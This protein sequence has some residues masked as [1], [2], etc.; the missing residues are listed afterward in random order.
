M[1]QMD[2][3]LDDVVLKALAKETRNNAYQQASEL[4]TQ[5]ETIAVV[6]CWLVQQCSC[7]ANAIAGTSQQWHTLIQ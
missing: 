3:R 5:V 1:V 6:H 4:R 2:V 7:Q